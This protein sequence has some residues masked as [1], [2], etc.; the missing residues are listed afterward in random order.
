MKKLGYKTV[1]W[2]GGFSTGKMLRISPYLKALM[3]S[4]MRPK[5]QAMKV[6]RGA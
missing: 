2:Y 5:C 1:F 3:N 6:M 4:M